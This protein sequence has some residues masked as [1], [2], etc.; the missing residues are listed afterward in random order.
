MLINAIAATFSI[1][2]MGIILFKSDPTATAR[3]VAKA[4]PNRAET[5]IVR[6]DFS[7]ADKVMVA[8]CVLSPSSARK[9]RSAVE[10]KSFIALLL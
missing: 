10:I 8:N 5:K 2:S 6:G 7:F 1:I 4:K 3:S 9:I